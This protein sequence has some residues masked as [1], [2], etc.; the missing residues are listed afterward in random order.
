MSGGVTGGPCATR[1]GDE[2]E[3]EAGRARALELCCT[4]QAFS[5]S[6][7]PFP[8]FSTATFSIY[9]SH[10]NS[11]SHPTPRASDP[12]PDRVHCAV[13]RQTGAWQETACS[14]GT[15]AGTVCAYDKPGVDCAFPPLF[16]PRFSSSFYVLFPDSP[17]PKTDCMQ[18]SKGN[19][20]GVYVCMCVCVWWHGRQ[21]GAD[22]CEP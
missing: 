5:S 1:T 7:P 15:E 4:L 14:T 18:H 22:E 11:T 12:S 9:S 13:A 8:P 20:C 3:G 19:M 16:S 6:L 21:V 17:Y 2:W 10:T